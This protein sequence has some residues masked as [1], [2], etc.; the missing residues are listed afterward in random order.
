MNSILEALRKSSEDQDATQETRK[1]RDFLFGK[2]PYDSASVYWERRRQMD[3]TAMRRKVQAAV[4]LGGFSTVL[5]LV[6]VIYVL[7][8]A[9]EKA[10]KTSVAPI[11]SVA[12]VPEPPAKQTAPYAT[13]V[14]ELPEPFEQSAVYELPALEMP[15]V[16]EPVE[17]LLVQEITE[18]IEQIEQ[19]EEAAIFPR[20]TPLPM[21]LDDA[22][23]RVS[24][25]EP[26]PRRTA[27]QEP[28]ASAFDLQGIVWDANDPMAMINGRYAHIGDKVSGA[29]VVEITKNTA[30]LEIRGKRVTIR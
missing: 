17:P 4:F 8:G 3:E 7:L 23:T 25:P 13:V 27:L 9:K 16:A 24:T 22:H 19:E 21:D 2:S 10:S 14:A 6:V 20:S 5:A 30:V 29:E 15:E 18:E 11:A 12:S 28:S 26:T 1:T